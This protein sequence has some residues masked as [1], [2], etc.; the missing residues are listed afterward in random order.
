MKFPSLFILVGALT[1]GVSTTS[2][3]APFNE[4]LLVNPGAESGLSGW[5]TSGMAPIAGSDWHAPHGGTQAFSTTYQ[6]GSLTQTVDLVAAGFSALELDAGVSVSFSQWVI[7]RF[8]ADAN[9]AMR[10]RLLGEEGAFLT[11][12]SVGTIDGETFDGP[13]LPAGAEWTEESH[14]FDAVSGVRTVE[15]VVAGKSVPQW[16]G[17]FGAG[18]DD[19]SLV[20]TAS[21]VPEPAHAVALVGAVTLGFCALRR[22]R[23]SG[24]DEV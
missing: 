4:N 8:D 13:T 21:T 24:A 20:V 6:W 22:R 2:A 15:V 5:T 10:V 18:F 19:A 23:R 16:G 1:A 3:A 7:S 17:Y 12:W 9:Y 11:E 14:V